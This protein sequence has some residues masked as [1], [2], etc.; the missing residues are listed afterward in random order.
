V[1]PSLRAFIAASFIFS[2]V[3]KSGSPAPKPII[4]TPCAFSAFAFASIARVGD[5]F[6]PDALLINPSY[7]LII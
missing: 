1:K 5:G 2:G 3:S 4:S 6:I 7:L